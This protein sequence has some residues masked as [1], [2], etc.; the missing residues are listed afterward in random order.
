MAIQVGDRIPDATL[1]SVTASGSAPVTT[2]ELFEG[3]KVVLFAVP[4][5][6]TPVCN[7]QHLPGYLSQAEAIRR[8]AWT[9][10]RASP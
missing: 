10:L 7:N 8:R 6:F 1:T 5:A 9:R 2:Q 3:K 4:G